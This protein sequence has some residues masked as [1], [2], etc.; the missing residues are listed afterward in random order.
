MKNPWVH[1]SR[2]RDVRQ[3]AVKRS[4]HGNNL[5]EGDAQPPIPCYGV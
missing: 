1:T 2:M 5:V 3:E 4:G